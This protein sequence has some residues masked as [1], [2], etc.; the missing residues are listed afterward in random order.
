M[1]VSVMDRFRL[2]IVAI[3]ICY[4]CTHHYFAAHDQLMIRICTY[5]MSGD[6]TVFNPI[7][8]RKEFKDFGDHLFYKEHK[9]ESNI[10]NK[11]LS[12]IKI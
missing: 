1:C 3:S 6:R 4:L 2:Y 10:F 9:L 12:I 7:Q 8:E 5:D 11:L